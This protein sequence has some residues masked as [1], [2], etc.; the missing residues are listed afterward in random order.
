MIDAVIMTF[1]FEYLGLE[2]NLNTADGIDN[3]AKVIHK[4][5]VGIT[6]I[7]KAIPFSSSNRDKSI[8]LIIEKSF[9]IMVLPLN[10]MNEFIN[11]LFIKHF[12]YVEF[13]FIIKYAS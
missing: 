1:L 10:I 13:S 9:V 5:R 11:F 8:L 4:L 3:C 12:P 6:N 7:Y 2:I